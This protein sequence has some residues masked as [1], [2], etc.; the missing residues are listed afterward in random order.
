MYLLDYFDEGYKNFGLTYQTVLNFYRHCHFHSNI[1]RQFAPYNCRYTLQF[2][3]DDTVRIIFIV[4]VPYNVFFHYALLG[5]REDNYW[6]IL[7]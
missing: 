4:C 3:D 2:T 5:F 6:Y 7:Q 1:F